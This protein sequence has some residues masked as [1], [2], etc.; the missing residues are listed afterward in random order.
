MSKPVGWRTR[1]R[2]LRQTGNEAL[3]DAHLVAAYNSVFAQGREDVEMVLSDLANFAGFYKVAE[4]GASAD[5]LNFD[6][7]KR[8]AFARIWSFLTLTDRQLEELENAARDE[9][10]G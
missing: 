8:A 6:E 4:R 9:A 10:A 2:E 1:T 5:E 7:G 3:S